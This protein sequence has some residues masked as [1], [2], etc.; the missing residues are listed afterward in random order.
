[1][2]RLVFDSLQLH[3][4]ERCFYLREFVFSSKKPIDIGQLVRSHTESEA[5]VAAFDQRVPFNFW[6]NCPC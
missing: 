2:N 3:T 4:F 5:E 1:M 6:L